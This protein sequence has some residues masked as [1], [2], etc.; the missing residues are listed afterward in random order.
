MPPLPHPRLRPSAVALGVALLL[1]CAIVLLLRADSGRGAG[2]NVIVTP[3]PA[4]G[5]KLASGTCLVPVRSAARF[6]ARTKRKVV[7]LTFDD[8][9][10]P[11]TAQVLAQLRRAR[12][13]ATFFVIGRQISGFAGDLRQAVGDGDAVGN[14]TWNHVD[15][16]KGGPVAAGELLWTSRAIRRATGRPPCVMRAPYGKTGPGLVA[17]ARAQGMVVTEWNVDPQDWRS[18][19]AARTT[20]AV[21][22]ALRPGAIVIL[23]DGGPRAQET[24]QALPRILRGLKRRGYRSVTVPQL[25]H[26]HRVR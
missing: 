2:S 11:A 24:V 6:D 19:S 26:L 8:G 7:A 1:V 3:P 17:A 20:R 18:P 25:L 10:G 23:H 5:A 16:S 4:P 9:P 13:H 22:S 14:H 21:L 12:Q 15:V